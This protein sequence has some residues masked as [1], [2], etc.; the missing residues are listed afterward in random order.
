MTRR[1][2]HEFALDATAAARADQCFFNALQQGFF[3]QRSFIRFGQRFLG[4][5]HQINHDTRQEQNRH[6]Q[7]GQDLREDVAR[8]RAHI[9]ESPNDQR[10]P[11][12]GRHCAEKGQHCQ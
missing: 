5:Q 12:R 1:A 10:Q 2:H 11:E 8:T 3:F 4:A 9:A 6:Q 7:R